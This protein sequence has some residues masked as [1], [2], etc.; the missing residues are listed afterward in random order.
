MN[1]LESLKSH[2]D[3]VVIGGG[4]NGCGIAREC[5]YQG[6]SVVCFDKSDFASGTSSASSKLIHGGLRYLENFEFSL[7]KEALHERHVLLKTAPHLVTS[8]GL[9]IPIFPSSPWSRLKAW[10]GVV[11]YDVLAMGKR[12][13][14]GKLL[15][16]Q[17]VLDFHPYIRKENLKGGVLYYDA[18]VDDARLV[19]ELA[20]QAQMWNADMYN[21]VS[22]S[23]VMWNESDIA[24]VHIEDVLSGNRAKVTASVV[25]NAT[26]VWS[27]RN[28]GDWVEDYVPSVR[29]SKGVHILTKSFSVDY[30]L[31][32]HAPQDG[33]VFFVLPYQGY[34]LIGT[35]DTDFR[36]DIDQLYV[37]ESD[38]NYLLSATNSLFPS[39]HLDKSDVISSFVGLRPL[40]SSDDSSVGKV[41]RE[42]K[43]V[44]HRPNF[45]SVFGGKYT[46]FRAVSER[47]SKRVCHYLNRSKSYRSTERLMLPGAGVEDNRG[48]AWYL[49]QQF[50]HRRSFN[51]EFI[52]MLIHRYGAASPIVLE[53]CLEHGSYSDYL[54]GTSYVVA[55]LLY[56]IRYEFVRTPLDFFRRRTSVFF[57][58]DH[59]R[60]ALD[61]VVD[62]MSSELMWDDDVRLTCTREFFAQ[63]KIQ[64]ELSVS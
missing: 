16:V 18:Q 10:M 27:D 53:I 47:V 30:G 41:S 25:V 17:S 58:K 23:N 56:G 1:Q 39:L 42:D 7:V 38:I 61:R 55:E 64:M 22:V 52:E 60:L 8:L 62:V 63:L 4:I 11:L 5:A 49:R 13:K 15:D 43:I 31:L 9:V 20:Q 12:I 26:G 29:P 40:V 19:V 6:L 44:M 48:Y 51:V 34:T 14:P 45:I 50:S 57:Q 35:T 3:V 36:G 32:G 2:Y 33:R 54:P 46:T 28:L 37:T 21:Y 24:Q 59:G